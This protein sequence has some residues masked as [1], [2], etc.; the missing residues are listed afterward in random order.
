MHSQ[1]KNSFP[2]PPQVHQPQVQTPLGEDNSADDI[3]VQ[4]SPRCSEHVH[5]EVTLQQV[6]SRPV[7]DNPL[8]AQLQALPLVLARTLRTLP[9]AL[10]ALALPWSGYVMGSLPLPE[11]L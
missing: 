7:P 3:S 8:G 4:V 1:V 6:W 9:E 5:P 2:T 10:S 11:A